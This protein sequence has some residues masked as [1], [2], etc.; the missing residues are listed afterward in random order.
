M[1][2]KTLSV[3]GLVLLAIAFLG[4]PYNA[5]AYYL[6]IGLAFFTVGVSEIFIEWW[7][8]IRPP[9]FKTP[10]ECPFCNSDSFLTKCGDVKRVRCLNPF[11][12]AA[13]GSSQFDEIA[14]RLWNTRYKE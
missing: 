12:G 7:K 3:F 6:S 8:T 2:S 14:I 13:G 11:C 4:A 1:V 10:A 9:A 5:A